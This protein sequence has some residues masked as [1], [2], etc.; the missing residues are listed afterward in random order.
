MIV[1]YVFEQYLHFPYLL[2]ETYNIFIR[3][4]LEGGHLFAFQKYYDFMQHLNALLIPLQSLISA[5]GEQG[6]F[7]LKLANCKLSVSISS[8]F[9]SCLTSRCYQG[10]SIQFLPMQ[11][12]NSFLCWT[13]NKNTERLGEY[14]PVNS[15]ADQRGR[16]CVSYRR[17]DTKAD[18]SSLRRI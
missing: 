17:G 6:A 13:T 5:F 4:P 1:N 11:N 15:F 8:V 10:I 7:S 14:F 18:E 3:V 12:H 2:N 16:C 9:H